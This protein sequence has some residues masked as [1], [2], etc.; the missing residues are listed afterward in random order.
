MLKN[1]RDHPANVKENGMKLT[2][3]IALAACLTFAWVAS[4]AAASKSFVVMP[5]QV[6]GPQSYAY[7]EKAIPS[8]L[9]SRLTWQGH[10]QPVSQKV[11][12]APASANEAQKAQAAVRADYAVWGTIT[13]TDSEALLNVHVRD[14]A[15]KDWNREVKT[16]VSG[17]IAAVQNVA[18]N[19]NREIFGRP[20]SDAGNTRDG[21]KP[22]VNQMNPDIVVN[23][24]G[25]Q[26]VYLNPQFRYQG[27]GTEDGS[28]LRSTTLPYVMVDFAVG[29]FDGNGR[30][31]IAVLS[32]HKMYIYEWNG[33][34]LKQLAEHTVS[35]GNQSFSMRAI[36]LNRDKAKELVVTTFN[37]EDNRPYSFI[38]SFKGGKLREYCKRSEYFLNVV[39]M[40]PNFTPTLVGQSWDGLKLFRPGVYM[41]Q[42]NGDKYVPGT[43]IAL[44]EGA[45]A[46]NFAWI[47]EGSSKEGDKL[48]ISSPQERLKIY[49]PK[50]NQ[51]HQTMDR[52]HGSSV[53]MDHYK[54]MDGLGVDRRYQLPE[55]YY[56]PM[57][58]IAID[59]ERKGEYVL[60]VNKPISTASQFFDRYRYF[61]QGE[62]HALY[63]DG[64]GMGLK[65]KTRRI[66]GSV[67]DMDMADINNDG[68]M[69]LVVG[70]NTHPG[71]VGVAQ[72]RCMITAYPLDTSLTNPNTPPDNSDFEGGNN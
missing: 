46:F 35:M 48:V 64:V 59:L 71:V 43:K 28:R 45:N 52:F 14:K 1:L 31:Q 69:D 56:A 41:M 54:T 34:K 11:S 32:D 42:W 51:I 21:N 18:G 66:R 39:N 10:V 27:A 33:G 72:R 30:N 62:V 22:M 57:R 68:I 4:A 38:Y 16:P 47:P 49:S 17:L 36:D 55:K 15:G 12:K 50:G 63:W 6:N 13:V 70:L 37:S 2:L 44:P 23:E 20:F 19:I 40:P 24:T 53:G 29:D 58:M 67:V 5:F 61:P 65:W 60:L 7:L 9:T 3:R 26:Q 25:Q 8:T